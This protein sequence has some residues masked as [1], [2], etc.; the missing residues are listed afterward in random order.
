[1]VADTE[2]VHQALPSPVSAPV[3]SALAAGATKSDSDVNVDPQRESTAI[4]QVEDL[5]GGNDFAALDGSRFTLEIAN[6][7]S[8]APLHALAARLALDGAVYLIHLRSP[9]ADRWLLTWSDHA[10]QAQARAAR[11]LVPADA[12]I[13]SGWPR[14]VAPL[15]RELASH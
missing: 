7:P 3:A 12:A 2:P 9:D 6:A 15:Q 4:G 8:A 10:T 14:R 11:A 5:L 13:N 1:M